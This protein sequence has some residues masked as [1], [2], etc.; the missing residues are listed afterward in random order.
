[1]RRVFLAI[2][3]VLW[4]VPLQA[5]QKVDRLAQAMHLSHVMEIL[6]QEGQVHREEL[7]ET[8]LDKTGGA[9]FETQV[10][11]IYDPDWMQKQ[12][13]DAF[14]AGLSDAQLDQAILFFESDLGQTIV[15][16][17]NSARQAMSD[18][19]IED[20]AREAYD[21][22]KRNTTRFE[23]VDEYIQANDLID[24]NVQG[25]LSSDYNFFRGLDVDAQGDDQELLAEL[26]SQKKSR[27]A[28]TEAWL[29]SFLLMAYRPLDETQMRENIA[30]SRTE[31]GRALNEA[32][33]DGFDRMFNDISF[34]MG[35]A[36]AQTLRASDL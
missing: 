4:G 2:V 12:L 21:S 18:Q 31:T 16:L 15:A 9:F 14:E 26:L 25:A 6:V 19:A 13:T 7:D 30:F 32:L 8:L 29:Y 24:K 28:E 35:R 22:V 5:D 27:A 3:V 36:V 34:R 23:L 20:M 17:E 1:M 11:D 10:R 33:F